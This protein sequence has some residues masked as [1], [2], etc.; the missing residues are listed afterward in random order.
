MTNGNSRTGTF[1][2]ETGG[3]IPS[4]GLSDET[5]THRKRVIQGDD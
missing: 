3:L 1:E 4:G 5:S 2:S